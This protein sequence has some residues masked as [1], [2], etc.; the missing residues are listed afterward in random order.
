MPAVGGG[1]GG[2]CRRRTRSMNDG[3]HGARRAGLIAGK[4][5][6]Q[7]YE[8]VSGIPVK[9]ASRRQKKVATGSSHRRPRAQGAHD[10]G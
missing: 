4:Q 8:C 1:G 5:I 10:I 6:R 7:A 3:F 9:S 2:V